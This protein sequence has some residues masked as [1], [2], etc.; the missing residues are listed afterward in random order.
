MARLEGFGVKGAGSLL[1]VALLTLSSF[2]SA[3]AVER[4]NAATTSLPPSAVVI[5][6]DGRMSLEDYAR[7]NSLSSKAVAARFGATG[8]V[9]CGQAVGTGQLVGASNV[10]VTA[11][12]VLF[13]PG[14]RSRGAGTTCTFEID[15]GGKRQVVEL[16][17]DTVQSGCKEPYAEP[18]IR[19]WAVAALVEPVIGVRPYMLASAMSVPG[20]IVL[21]SAARS[22]GVEN[23][24]LERCKAREVTA[25]SPAGLREVAIDC[26]AEGGTSGA[27][28]LTDTG[29]FLG[30]Y[31]GFRSAHP[32]AAGPFSMS[33]YNFGL[34]A[35]GAM[36]Q[37]IME[38]VSRN[39]PLSASR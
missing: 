28:M 36:R 34:T 9:R 12:H 17:L 8:L 4:K 37:A 3:H 29:G 32:G 31:V 7:A 21:T 22:G 39:Q 23:H 18:A 35:E 20:D 25:T 13:A 33:H 6:E 19:D 24:S 10:V 2:P 11:A 5:D 16:K 1:C 30:L 14:G 26:D 38:V 27:A 15:A